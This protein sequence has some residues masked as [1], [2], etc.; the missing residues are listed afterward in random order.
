[1]SRHRSKLPPFVPL[2]RETL[3]SAA[4]GAMSHGARSLYVALKR[5][6]NSDFHNNGKIYLSLRDA[7]Q[8]IGSGREEIAALASDRMWLHERSA[9]AGL[10]EVGWSQVQAPAACS[11]V[12][13]RIPDRQGGP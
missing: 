8:E 9:D 11:T 6:Y 12:K 2:L 13:N 7:S 3:D 5:R 10:H 4:W 1:M